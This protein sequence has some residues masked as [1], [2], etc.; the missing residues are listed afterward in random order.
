MTTRL[1]AVEALRP[2]LALG[3]AATIEQL[4]EFIAGRTGVDVATSQAVLA[5]LSEA[6][7]FFARQGRPVTIDGLST[8]SPS[9]DLS[10]EFDCT[11]RLDR[12]IV[13]ALNQPESYSGEIANRENIGKA[14][15]ELA[16][17]WD[18]AHPEDKVR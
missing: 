17:L 18:Q 13:L 7:I 12:K 10:G 14:T 8:Y 15:A 2:R 1:E 3:P 4:A 6:V 11:G 16:A 5:E 9:I